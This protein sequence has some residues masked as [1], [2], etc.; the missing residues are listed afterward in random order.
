MSKLSRPLDGSSSRSR[1]VALWKDARNPSSIE[2][3]LPDKCEAMV[4]SLSMEYREEWTAD[5]RSDY[6]G[7]GYPTLSGIHGVTA[8]VV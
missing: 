3:E 8:G 2:I 7:A 6:G 4:L 1:V 5:G